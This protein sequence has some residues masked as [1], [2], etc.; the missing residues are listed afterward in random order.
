MGFLQMQ[1][2]FNFSSDK[3]KKKKGRKAEERV[4]LACSTLCP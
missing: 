4:L 3:K 2:L 1:R